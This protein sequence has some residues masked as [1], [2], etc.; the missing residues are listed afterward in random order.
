LDGSERGSLGRRSTITWLRD[1]EE[2]YEDIFTD[3]NAALQVASKQ[4]GFDT[5]PLNAFQ[6]TTY[7]K[8]GY[9][10]WHYDNAVP[11]DRRLLS[12]SVELQHAKLGGGLSFLPLAGAYWSGI[13]HAGQ[14]G[15]AT[16]FP[17]YL[18]HQ[19]NTVWLGQRIS[20][21]GWVNETN[22]D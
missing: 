11:G 2:G 13:E 6:L 19:A 21:V 9:Y 12:I 14:I 20:L 10:R 17:T 18:I 16:I 7:N 3:V 15:A 8:L 22:K 5:E 4:Y 1:S